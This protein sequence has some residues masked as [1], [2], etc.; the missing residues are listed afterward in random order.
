MLQI[1]E[2][3]EWEN[4]N[5]CPGCEAIKE[6]PLS[7]ELRRRPREYADVL[8]K[9]ERI[10]NLWRTATWV[11]RLRKLVSN[12][13]LPEDQK[14][15]TAFSAIHSRFDCGEGS[16]Q[17]VR[18]A[19]ELLEKD[20]AARRYSIDTMKAEQEQ[21]RRELPPSLV[22]LTEQVGHAEQLEEGIKTYAQALDDCTSLE[23]KLKVRTEWTEFIRKATETF[24][25]AEVELSTQKTIALES[26][27]QSL[28]QEI[29]NN[30]DIIPALQKSTGGEELHLLLKNFYGLH[31]LSAATLLAE[32]YRNA[33][34]IAIFLSALLHDRSP[35]RF[36]VMDD[37]TSSFDAGHQFALMEV[38][39]TRIARPLNPSGP[40]V[41]MLS[42]DGLLEKYF[43][44][45][46]SEVSWHHQMSSFFSMRQNEG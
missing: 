2:S 25:Q 19:R 31:N 17:D 10:S 26:E 42:H 4:P 39:R 14:K 30:P 33:L 12:P 16:A 46:S 32:S 20:E 27:Y 22:A 29:S 3:A 13:Y 8:E 21:L 40:Q 34:A 23:A 7:P 11:T 37:I 6:A 36:I 28:Y 44:R 9:S 38:I 5:A 1:L 18:L 15:Q 45:L 43:D 24:S 41:L 35:P